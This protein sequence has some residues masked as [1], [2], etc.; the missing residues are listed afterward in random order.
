MLKRQVRGCRGCVAAD[1]AEI[2]KERNE[3]HEGTGK[4]ARH[5]VDQRLETLIDQTHVF[6]DLHQAAGRQGD[7]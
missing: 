5:T 2:L 7:E 4:K 3:V 6:V 1:P